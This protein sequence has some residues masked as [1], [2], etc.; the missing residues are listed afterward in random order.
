M[1][2]QVVVFTREAA[3]LDDEDVQG[4]DWEERAHQPTW[5]SLPPIIN[6]RVIR[7]QMEVFWVT[8]GQELR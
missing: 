8:L 4:K 3:K 2:G 6:I 1:R 5:N 7:E